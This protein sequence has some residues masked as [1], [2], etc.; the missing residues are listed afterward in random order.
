MN[1]AQGQLEA[2][3]G[4]VLLAIA[5]SNIWVVYVAG[6]TRTEFEKR[7]KL[8]RGMIQLLVETKELTTETRGKLE[9]LVNEQ[10]K[11]GKKK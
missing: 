10:K 3:T 11:P 9:A 5:T 4:L 2:T 1:P 7:D 8:M 6:H